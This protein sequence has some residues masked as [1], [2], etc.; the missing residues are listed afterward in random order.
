MSTTPETVTE[1]LQTGLV[2]DAQSSAEIPVLDVG[3][4]LSGVP[5]AREQLAP[6]LS[7]ALTQVGFF[8]LVGHHI[9]RTVIDGVFQEAKR[10]LSLPL[11]QKNTIKLNDVFVGYM[12]DRQQ[13]GR[14]SEYYE[15]HTKPDRVEAFFMQR[16]RSPFELP[17]PN[18]WPEGLPGYRET[19]IEFFEAMEDLSIKL[20]PLFATA[21]SLPSDYFDPVFSKISQYCLPAPFSLPGRPFGGGSV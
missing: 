13:L 6:V 4:Y 3:D 2:S 8:Y 20:L 21:L 12:G 17:F 19:L 11:E 7:Q 18:Q 1:T 14:T 10:F 16:D 9:P 15:G 5:G